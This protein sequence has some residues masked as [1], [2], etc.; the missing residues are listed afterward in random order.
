MSGDWYRWDKVD[1]IDDLDLWWRTYGGGLM[2]EDLQLSRLV[3]CCE[4]Y[5]K[6]GR[7]T[8]IWVTLAWV[9]TRALG[10]ISR[11]NDSGGRPRSTLM[12]IIRLAL[13]ARWV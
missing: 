12:E 8:A 2:V 6:C 10:S 9:G 7:V 4:L 5:S 13:T 11:P 3:S 1:S